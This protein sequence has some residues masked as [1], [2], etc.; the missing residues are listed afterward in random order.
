MPAVLN[1]ANEIAV[2]SFLEIHCI[3]RYTPCDPASDGFS[4]A[5]CKAGTWGQYFRPTHGREKKRRK[6]LELCKIDG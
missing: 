4:R 1:A 5:V 2:H 6:V 3:L